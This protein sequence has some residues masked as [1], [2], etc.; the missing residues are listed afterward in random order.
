LATTRRGLVQLVLQNLVRR[1]TDGIFDPLGFEALVDPRHGE[2]GIGAEAPAIEERVLPKEA[3]MLSKL[4]MAAAAIL[5]SLLLIRALPFAVPSCGE[6]RRRRI[7]G[8]QARH[9]TVASRSTAQR[10]KSRATVTE[11]VASM[12]VGSVGNPQSVVLERFEPTGAHPPGNGHPGTVF[13][14]VV[15]M[16]SARRGAFASWGAHQ[17]AA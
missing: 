17:P 10:P 9:I 13:A 4:S 3:Q 6:S 11:I 7:S 16:A 2:G 15:R 12:A 8:R 14:S 1:Q 5:I